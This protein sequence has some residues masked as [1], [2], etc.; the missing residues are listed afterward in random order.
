MLITP[1]GLQECLLAIVLHVP[2]LVSTCPKL[3]LT[4]LNIIGASGRL[5]ALR[6]ADLSWIA[7]EHLATERRRRGVGVGVGVSVAIAAV[8]GRRHVRWRLPS[9]G[10]HVRATASTAGARVLLDTGLECRRWSVAGRVRGRSHTSVVAP[11]R[12]RCRAANVHVSLQVNRK[13]AV[14]HVLELRVCTVHAVG[15]GGH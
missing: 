7:V 10:T 5:S 9:D 14:A 15:T 6:A 13:R 3:A 1:K 11:G 8:R 12:C 4:A 2:F